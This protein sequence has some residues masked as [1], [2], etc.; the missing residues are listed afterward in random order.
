MENRIIQYLQTCFIPSRF[1][2]VAE[3]DGAGAA[4]STAPWP[5]A[6]NSTPSLTRTWSVRPLPDLAHDE[7]FRSRPLYSSQLCLVTRQR[8]SGG[9]P[10]GVCARKLVGT[11]PYLFARRDLKNNCYMLN[12]P[13]PPS[14]LVRYAFARSNTHIYFPDHEAEEVFVKSVLA[15]KVR[16]TDQRWDACVGDG[17]GQSGSN[18][19][20]GHSLDVD[21]PPVKCS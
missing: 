7:V 5:P 20:E 10:G 13:R 16:T 2:V 8:R 1:P 17:G 9:G 21:T 4:L 15:R 6:T 12:A 18:V 14:R 19:R 3:F 11:Y